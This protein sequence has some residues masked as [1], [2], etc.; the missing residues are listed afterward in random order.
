M[1]LNNDTLSKTSLFKRPSDYLLFSFVLFILL[2]WSLLKS[3]Q[4]YLD[5]KRFSWHTFEATVISE[6]KLSRQSR[7]LY[8][9]R[10]DHFMFRTSTNEP[11]INLEG[12]KVS[13]T[14]LTENISFVKYIKGFYAPARF[15]ALQRHKPVRTK[16]IDA[17][18][19]THTSSLIG[20]L[21]AA[22]Y[23]AQPIQ[24]ELRE[25]LTQF[26]INHLAAISGFH[27][28]LISLFVLMLA[29]L[30]YK[31]LHQKYFPFRNR[32][33]DIMILTLVILLIYV[34]FLE[35]TP[36]LLRAFGMMLIGFILYDRGLLL[37]S[38]GSLLMTVLLL[39]ALF[40]DLFF[41]MGFWL[42]V[43]GVFHL[44]LILKQWEDMKAWKLFILLHVAVFVF[45]VPWIVYIF[46]SLSI[47]QL[48]SPLLSI[49][50]IIFYPLSMVLM[51]LGMG[52]VMDGLLVA[53][54]SMEFKSVTSSMPAYTIIIYVVLLIL[55][56]RF[57]WL[58]YV[59]L[60]LASLGLLLYLVE[61]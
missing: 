14:L 48:L 7:T 29:N 42:S 52:N 9:L 41:S 50:F 28:G 45:M 20:N 10:T 26:G 34:A 1:P 4:S 58:F 27:L 61:H 16:L 53:L 23:L 49:L 2:S 32:T 40:P 12:R 3:Y 35:F 15:E 37:L 33:R 55:S 18:H 5:L 21:Y 11:I 43:L 51:S 44:F 31:P 39:L 22:L 30:I 46:G 19:K 36:S 59:T 38:F 13:V 25:K 47:G 54:L 8:K 6:Q 17:I 60:A 56:I 24:Q 57:K